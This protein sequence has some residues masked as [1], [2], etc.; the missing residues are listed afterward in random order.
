MQ[1]PIA[2][3]RL[4][5][6]Y[7][8]PIEARARLGYL[9][10]LSKSSEALGLFDAEHEAVRWDPN[11]RVGFYEQLRGAIALGRAECYREAGVGMAPV[12]YCHDYGFLA[13]LDADDLRALDLARCATLPLGGNEGNTRPARLSALARELAAE[14]DPLAALVRAA[15]DRVAR[16]KAFLGIYRH[17]V[18]LPKEVERQMLREGWSEGLRQLGAGQPPRIAHSRAKLVWSMTRLAF[19]VWYDGPRFAGV[20]RLFRRGL[21]RIIRSGRRCPA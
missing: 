10:R 14:A 8:N 12:D 1:S 19:D 4:E 16:Y 11:P 7:L 21:V 6:P 5:S 18:Q 13:A 2:D 15:K 17:A 20:D 9:A 3:D